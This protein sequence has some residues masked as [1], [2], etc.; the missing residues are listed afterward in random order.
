VLS[1]SGLGASGFG[2]TGVLFAV[3][4]FFAFIEKLIVTFVTGTFEGAR[5]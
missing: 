2:I 5:T 4:N 3:V 1:R